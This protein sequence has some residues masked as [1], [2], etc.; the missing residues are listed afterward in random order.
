MRLNFSGADES[1][2]REGVRRLGAI[3][4]EQVELFGTMT[5]RVP[6]PA[7]KPPSEPQEGGRVVP[8]TPIEPEAESGGAA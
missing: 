5:G 7:R 1:E 4:G 3:V 6:R 2:I 8:F